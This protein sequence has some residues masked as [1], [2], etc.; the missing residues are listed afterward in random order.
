MNRLI[1][2]GMVDTKSPRA[3]QKTW[4]TPSGL[5]PR[6]CRYFLIHRSTW[7][8]ILGNVQCRKHM[9]ADLGRDSEKIRTTLLSLAGEFSALRGE[10]TTNGITR[11]ILRECRAGRG[12]QPAHCRPH[13]RAYRVHLLGQVPMQ[14]RSDAWP[15]SAPVPVLTPTPDLAAPQLPWRPDPRRQARL[16]GL[17][18]GPPGAH[19]P[20]F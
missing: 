19:R 5:H 8:Y 20:A 15:R 3:S 11:Q 4:R 6:Y 16:P 7:A 2:G 9:R 10:T 1:F 13:P 14:L 17:G 12:L 18:W